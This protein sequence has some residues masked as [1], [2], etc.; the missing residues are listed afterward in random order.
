MNKTLI[1]LG[2]FALIIVAVVLVGLI[3]IFRPEATDKIITFVGTI[4]TVA[5]GAVVTFYMLGK[6]AAT[7]D[8]VKTQTNGTN[9]ALL[10]ANAELNR[11]L[12]HFVSV[13]PT[14]DQTPPVT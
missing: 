14:S 6:Q 7:L 4:L 9:T 3:T 12:L 2:Y 10:A 13:A 11:K 1:I 5:S 8:Q